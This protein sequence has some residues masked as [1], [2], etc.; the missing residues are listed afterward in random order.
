MIILKLTF[1]VAAATAAIISD[2]VIRYTDCIIIY[3]VVG[4]TAKDLIVFTTHR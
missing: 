4:R 1:L 3:G 2:R